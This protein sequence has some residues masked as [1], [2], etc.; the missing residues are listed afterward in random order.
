MASLGPQ[1]L[2]GMD[3]KMLLVTWLM[4]V[5]PPVEGV[6]PPVGAAALDDDDEE[7]SDQ[8][9]DGVGS[10]QAE[11]EDDQAAEELEAGVC[12][13]GRGQYMSIELNENC[14]QAR[15]TSCSR[16]RR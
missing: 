12:R 11:L 15:P 2:S 5:P 8:L 4:S 3:N 9:E 16:W 6:V 10:T 13:D 14:S 1:G 7:G